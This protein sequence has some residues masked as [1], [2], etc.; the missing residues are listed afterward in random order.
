MRI[1]L[2]WTTDEHYD[3]VP[4]D[5]IGCSAQEEH[6][7]TAEWIRG[8][9][10]SDTTIYLFPLD[11]REDPVRSDEEM[12]RRRARKLRS[13]TRKFRDVLSFI[14]R[15]LLAADR[16][17]AKEEYFVLLVASEETIER[18]MGERMRP[19]MIFTQRYF[20]EK[21]YD[22]EFRSVSSL[23]SIVSRRWRSR[24]EADRGYWKIFL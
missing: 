6:L 17:R 20:Y 9:W 18:Q 14:K 23:T 2:D 5:L 19:A 1:R 15:L 21:R 3:S 11:G 24:S 8:D 13:E 12:R 4:Y 7:R 16:E 22:E 10:R